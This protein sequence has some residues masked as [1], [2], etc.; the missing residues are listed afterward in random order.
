MTIPVNHRPFPIISPLTLLTAS[1]NP[2]TLAAI[3]LANLFLPSSLTWSASSLLC[4]SSNSSR[5]NVVG[6]DNKKLFSTGLEAIV[7]E[8]IREW[9]YERRVSLFFSRARREGREGEDWDGV[10][11][12]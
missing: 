3:S 6:P 10:E 1:L 2:S 8:A 5:L 9:R 12:E 11:G 7:E 4:A